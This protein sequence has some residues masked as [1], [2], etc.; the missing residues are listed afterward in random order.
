VGV[1]VKPVNYYGNVPWPS[2]YR[3]GSSG[4]ESIDGGFS[5]DGRSSERGRSG[6][7]WRSDDGE[8]TGGGS[9]GDLRSIAA[10]EIGATCRTGELEQHDQDPKEKL[11]SDEQGEVA[12]NTS[13]KNA[14]WAEH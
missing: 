6:G 3:A 12:M 11:G 14:A 9:S 2:G 10:G 5:G 1:G 7:R 4:G 8:G 13:R